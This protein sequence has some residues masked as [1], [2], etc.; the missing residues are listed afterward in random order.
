MNNPVEIPVAVDTPLYTQRITLDGI[1]YIFKLDWFEREGRWYLS[2][3]TV[4]N[5]PLALGIKIVA[6][7]PILRR[8]KDARMPP[9]LLMAVDLSPM[10]G[11]PPGYTDL[12]T[13][14]RLHYFPANA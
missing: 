7:W 2:L 10:N 11:E 9:G 6:N 5:Q 8:F 12:G 1:E 4:D 3:Y 13:R 14:V